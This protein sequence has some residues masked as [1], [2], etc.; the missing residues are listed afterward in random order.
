MNGLGVTTVIT[1]NFRAALNML[2][3]FLFSWCWVEA[4]A[5]WDPYISWP[6]AVVRHCPTPGLCF[7]HGKWDTSQVSLLE[8]TYLLSPWCRVLLKNLTGSQLVK[9][10]PTY[11]GSRWFINASTRSPN[12]SLSWASSIQSTPPSIPLPEVPF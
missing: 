6:R 2:V 1:C 3:L 5:F 7:Q 4:L 10:L 11:Y 9:K 12:L 8:S